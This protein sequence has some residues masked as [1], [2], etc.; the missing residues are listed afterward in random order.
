[1]YDKEIFSIQQGLFFKHGTQIKV[2]YM[3]SIQVKHLACLC[4]VV[5]SVWVVVCH[6]V[7]FVEREASHIFLKLL[8]APSLSYTLAGLCWWP[9]A[10]LPAPASLGL[11]FS[12]QHHCGLS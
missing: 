8:A 4:F 6:W 10:L 5:S 12:S 2:V 7:V 11:F 3:A 9:S 1:M